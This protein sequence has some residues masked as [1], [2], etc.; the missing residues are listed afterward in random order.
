MKL[1]CKICKRI[2]KSYQA[3]ANHIVYHKIKAKEY[4][5]QYLKKD[6]DGVCQHPEC[7][8]YPTRF[9]N[10]RIGYIKHC[11]SKCGREATML[12]KYG[13]KN[14]SNVPEFQRKREKTLEKRY[15]K[16]IV[17][18]T[19]IP[20][21]REK[22]AEL[23]KKSF[24]KRYGDHVTN[25]VHVP[26]TVE[27]IKETTQKNHGV[28]NV[29][30]NPEIKKRALENQQKVFLEKYGTTNFGKIPGRMEKSKLT[31]LKKY[32]VEFFTQTSEYREKRRQ[33][34][35]NG[36]AAYILSFVKNPSKPQVILFK[37]CQ[38]IL[39]YP[40]MNYP[41]KN[42][43]IDIVIPQLSIAIEYDGSY[44]HQD[45]K[46]DKKR[47]KLLEDEGWKFLRYVDYIPT[48]KELLKDV[49]KLLV[50]YNM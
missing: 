11:C 4:Y 3:L 35:L 50:K 9:I 18:P 33:Y 36:G 28:D 20:A 46:A 45:E 48:K 15:G 14:P 23:I 41:C 32:G 49:N 10:I 1:E 26:G 7:E 16:G 2:F 47:Q 43:S 22:N 19:Q 29:M 40:I 13:V 30:Q 25:A 6:G 42:K 44:W 37:K 34:M 39:P 8:N 21:V 27:K 12:K 24:Q 31:S 17:N 38:T 5:D